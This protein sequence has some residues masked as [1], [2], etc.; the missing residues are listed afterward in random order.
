VAGLPIGLGPRVPMTVISPWS[1]GGWVNSQVFDHTSVIRF[2]ERWTGV[3]EPNISAWRRAITGDLTSCFDFRRRQMSIPALPDANEL[4]AIADQTRS[5]LPKPAPPAVGR[6]T[7]PHQEPGVRPA[8]P[9]PY[10]ATANASVRTSGDGRR[11]VRHRGVRRERLPA[12]VRR[13]AR[14]HGR[15]GATVRVTGTRP[16]AG[17][18]TAYRVPAGTTVTTDRN[19]TGDGNGWYDVLATVEGDRAFR[20][21]FAGHVENGEASVTGG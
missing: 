10:Q 20:R 8:R 1:R 11:H 9:I 13:Q 6:Q 12:G 14:R 2:L 3:H 17:R 15:R 21:R 16:G 7:V 4:Q 19:E 18:S 5:T